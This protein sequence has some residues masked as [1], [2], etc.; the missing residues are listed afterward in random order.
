M[1]HILKDAWPARIRRRIFPP[2]CSWPGIER[3]LHCRVVPC[4]VTDRE[5][6][7]WLESESRTK[8]P[9]VLVFDKT[10]GATEMAQV[11]SSYAIRLGAD[12]VQIVRGG[13]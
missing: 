3:I 10:S 13:S 8:A 2:R 7:G 4:L 6:D 1:A 11:T 9:R 5:L 12:E